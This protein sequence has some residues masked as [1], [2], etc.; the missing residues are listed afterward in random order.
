[1]HILVVNS[2]SSSIKFSMFDSR[3]GKNLSEPSCLFDGQVSNIGEPDATLE[4]QG[5]NGP[6]L[7]RRKSG[8]KAATLEEAAQ[9]VLDTVSEARMPP[10]QAVGYRVVHPGAKLHGHQ[11]I[12]TEVLKDLEEAVTFAPLHDP[13]AIAVIHKGMERFPAV[14]HYACFD[15]VF[16]RTMPVEASTYPVPRTYREQGVRR[17]GFH[18]LSCESIVR[19]M[20][21]QARAEGTGFPQRMV[22]AHLGSGCSV[23][24]LLDGCS[25]DTT[26]GLTPTGGVVMETRPGDLD[27]GLIL[28]LL[29][30]QTGDSGNAISTVETILNHGSGMVA[31]AGMAGDIKAVRHAAAKGDV[32]ALLALK[33]FTRSVTKAIGGF[34]WLLEGLDAIV[35]AGG[36]GEHDV[37]ARAEIL[38]GLQNL[39]VSVSPPLNEAKATGVRRISTS[40]S[41]TAIL[42]VP[43]R[44]DLMIAMHVD[45]LARSEE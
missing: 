6:S 15:T 39:G 14:A 20:R 35:F 9:L 45:R 38:S 4:L 26:M 34:C 5:E 32:Q 41:K 7:G 31:L 43:A 29:R 22:I 18:G 23:T 24:A 21:V 33:I 30:Q 36:V 28:Y 25:V 3:P 10:V 17:Y 42:V 13:A 44:E 37:L 27:P 1:M 19:Q 12:T 16:H 11:R 2:G 8:V 40:E